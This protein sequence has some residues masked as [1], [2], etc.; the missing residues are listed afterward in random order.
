MNQVDNLRLKQ[1]ARSVLALPLVLILT[2]ALNACSPV[3]VAPESRLVLRTESPIALNARTTQ[4]VWQLMPVRLPAY[5][6]RETLL[7]PGTQGLQVSAWRWAE[8]PSESAQRIL[9]A[10]L[11]TILGASR[12][13][14]GQ[15]PSTLQAQ[16]LRIEVQSLD[17]SPDLQQLELRARWSA[18]AQAHQT[19]LRVTL[20]SRSAA[21]VSLAH[22][23]ALAQLAQTIASTLP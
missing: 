20:A 16:P 13:W 23:T 8:L 2:W 4:S 11:A 1:A 21:D 9:A 12:L 3:S 18:G 5:L 15:V 7:M 17:L 22:R 19:N 14:N 6:D 10:D